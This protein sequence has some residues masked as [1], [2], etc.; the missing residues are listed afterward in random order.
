MVPNSAIAV[1]LLA[2]GSV[3][4]IAAVLGALIQH[5]LKKLL[6]FHAVSQVGYMVL[7]IGTG[8]PLGVAGG[9]FHMFNHAIYKSCLFLCGGAVEQGAGTT[10]LEKLG[11]LARY[12]PLTFIGLPDRGSFDL[13]DPAAKRF[14]L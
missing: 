8:L 10:D 1:L 12:M 14:F 13:G 11:G 4:I 5:D 3:T 9:L 7:G 2:V 6:S